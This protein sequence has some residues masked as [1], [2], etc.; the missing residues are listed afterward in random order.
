MKKQRGGQGTPS[1]ENPIS[2]NAAK[3]MGQTTEK[4]SNKLTAATDNLASAVNSG[5]ST[6]MGKMT[7]MG[8]KIT[9]GKN[10]VEGKVNDVVAQGKEKMQEA[11]QWTEKQKAAKAGKSAADLFTEIVP[12][13]NPIHLGQVA[14][15]K[16]IEAIHQTG[17]TLND[18]SEKFNA[19]KEAGIK[20]EQERI[21]A[22][23]AKA[24]QQ[25]SS[26]GGR[27]KRRRRTRRKKRRKSR[28]SR[29]KR[30]KSRKKFKK[31]YMWNKKGKRY[32][33]K[34]Y[35]QHIKGVR[36]GHTHKKP[37]KTRRRRRR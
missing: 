1:L 35:K 29:R 8:G 14:V 36:L 15:E 26:S 34:T 18:Q 30:R 13:P 3:D 31:H 9:E 12:N 23:K 28:K 17:E 16:S 21:A 33:V 32:R 7:E 24:A 4:L 27:R 6:G 11:E 25:Q 19:G 2:E 10:L 20:A 22:E 37:K 5:I